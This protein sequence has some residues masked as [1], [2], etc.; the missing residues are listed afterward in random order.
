MK[1]TVVIPPYQKNYITANNTREFAV[2]LRRIVDEHMEQIGE[3]HDGAE[4]GLDDT[5]Q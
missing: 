1:V 4:T 2:N 3:D 5:G